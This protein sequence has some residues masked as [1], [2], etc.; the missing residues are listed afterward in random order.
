MARVA[1]V[2]FAAALLAACASKGLPIAGGG[3]GTG[4]AGGNGPIGSGGD[5]GSGSIADAGV[6]EDAGTSSP[7][8]LA[9]PTTGPTRAVSFRIDAAHTGGQPRDHLALPLSLA[10]KHVETK[11]VFS[12]LV[13]DGR[14]F[15]LGGEGTLTALDT[16]SGATLWGPTPFSDMQSSA[17]DGGVLYVLGHGGSLTAVDAATGTTR[18]TIQ[19]GSATTIFFDAPPLAAD[20]KVFVNADYTLFAVSGTTGAILWKVPTGSGNEGTTAYA[21]GVLYL[22]NSCARTSAFDANTGTQQWLYQPTCGGGGGTAPAVYAH[23]VYVRDST[24]NKVFDAA[25]SQMLGTFDGMQP[26]SFVDGIGYFLKQGVSGGTL[27]A[28]DVAGGT[29]RWSFTGDGSL[30]SAPIACAGAVFVG[31]SMGNLYGL[32]TS[33]D[34]A[35]KTNLGMYD[36]NSDEPEMESMVIAEGT[37]FVPSGFTLFAFR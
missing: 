6:S 11:Y 31:S 13:A 29:L 20:G 3:G 17:Y 7:P 10:W 14:V 15:V 4:G 9:L 35:W 8:D 30:N 33:G 2:A 36:V 24:G 16:Q 18:W 34:V 37:L 19:L 32:D 1:R 28:V 5:A 23:D 25:G 12:V 26:P 21:D 22:A 27:E